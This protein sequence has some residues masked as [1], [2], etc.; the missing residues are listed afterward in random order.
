MSQPAYGNAPVRIQICSPVC[1][2][3]S[4]TSPEVQKRQIDG[5]GGDI[6]FAMHTVHGSPE[7]VMLASGLEKATSIQ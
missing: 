4:T 3:E 2:F 5:P 1:M 6:K 7:N